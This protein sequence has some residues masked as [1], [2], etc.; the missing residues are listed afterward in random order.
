MQASNQIGFQNRSIGRCVRTTRQGG[1]TQDGGHELD[2]A[3]QALSPLISKL[4]DLLRQHTAEWR[5]LSQLERV[6]AVVR[7]LS[8]EL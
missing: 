8:M 1:S 7:V 2:R 4:H 6:E 5:E 3:L